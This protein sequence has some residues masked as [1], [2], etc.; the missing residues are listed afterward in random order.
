MRENPAAHFNSALL[1]Q[2]FEQLANEPPELTRITFLVLTYYT[3]TRK[4]I[5]DGGTITEVS[6]SV[7]LYQ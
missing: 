2:S 6:K 1:L 7:M 4:R 3:N 5:C